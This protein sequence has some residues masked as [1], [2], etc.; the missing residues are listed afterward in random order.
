[1][2]F[3]GR[4]FMGGNLSQSE[5]GPSFVVGAGNANRETIRKTGL[6][7]VEYEKDTFSTGE[8]LQ[9][10]CVGVQIYYTNT[11]QIIISWKNETSSLVNL[12]LTN[13]IK[14][15]FLSNAAT[16][17]NGLDLNTKIVFGLAINASSEMSSVECWMPLEESS[18]WDQITKSL[19]VQ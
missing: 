18:K 7:I 6:Q 8:P 4:T 1:M 13:R 17:F 11:P 2:L 10:I 19:H 5:L 14:I 12:D 3:I 15:L 16:M 9:F